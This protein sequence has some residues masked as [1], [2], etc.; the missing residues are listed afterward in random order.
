M[1]EIAGYRVLPEE[2]V[3]LINRI[4]AHANETAALW[5]EV[6]LHVTRSKH[7]PGSVPDSEPARWAAIARTDLQQG[8]M[9][10][11]RAVAQP[12]GF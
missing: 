1:P 6:R 11:T 10:L 12:A 9:A 4:K 2:D 5:E 8:Y 7:V 3:A